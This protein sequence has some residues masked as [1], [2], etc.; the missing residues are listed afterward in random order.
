MVRGGMS[1]DVR[2]GEVADVARGGQ[3]RSENAEQR[4]N[5]SMQRGHGVHL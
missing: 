2:S 3:W 5:Q 4:G 1:R